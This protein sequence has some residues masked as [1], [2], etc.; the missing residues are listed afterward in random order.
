MSIPRDLKVDDPRRTARTRSTP[1]TRSAA[2]ARRVATVKQLFKDARARTSR[3]TTSINVNFGGFRRAVNYVGGVYVDVDRR[4]FNDNTRRR[5]ASYAT[6]DVEPGYQKL[7][8]QDALDYVRYRHGDN[9]FVRAAR[10]QDFLR[11]VTHQDGV[12]KLLDVGKR[13]KLARRSS[14]ATSRST[15]PSVERASSCRLL[16]ARALSWRSATRRSTRSASP[17]TT[18]R[19]RRS[20]RT[21]TS[22]AGALTQG[23]RRV[24]DRQGAARPSRAPN[25]D[26]AED[27]AV[28]GKPTKRKHNRPSSI[29]ASRRRATEGENLAVARRP[30]QL[31]VP[32]LLPG[33]AQHRLAL[34]RRPSR[35]STRIRDEQR[36]ARTRPTGW[37]STPARS[38]ST[39]ASRA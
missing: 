14:A 23:R 12:R 6:I 29:R 32:V 38:A 21:C 35:A 4:Y 37:C 11:Q 1:P 24:H 5:P 17:P 20:T 28:A 25:H 36:Q 9:D 22:T 27:D 31:E 2:R 33:A 13:K 19:T 3:S 16:Q 34:R 15:S 7:C 30:E 18:R 26:A 39:T 10:Q 8:G